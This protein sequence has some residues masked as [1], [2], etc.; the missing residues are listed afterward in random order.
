MSPLNDRRIR[1]SGLTLELPEPALARLHDH[2]V[3]GFPQE[4]VGLLAGERATGRIARVV[5]LEAGHADRPERGSRL[6]SRDA[7]RQERALQAQGLDVLGYYLSHCDQPAMYSDTERDAALPATAYLIAAVHGPRGPE[8]DSETT[9]VTDIRAWRLS[10][11][12]SEMLCD[13]LVV[14]PS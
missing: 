1:T 4:V 12:R 7:A 10:D 2:V 6:E 8:G 3:A 9:R 13:D 5:P 14:L 11:D